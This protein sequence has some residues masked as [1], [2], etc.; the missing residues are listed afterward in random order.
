[1][2]V[3][4]DASR[5]LDPNVAGAPGALSVMIFVQRVEL[6]DAPVAYS[7]DPSA[8]RHSIYTPAEADLSEVRLFAGHLYRRSELVGDAAAVQRRVISI[9]QRGFLYTSELAAVAAQDAAS[10]L[11]VIG[12]SLWERCGEPVYW[13]VPATRA[14]VVVAFIHLFR[15]SG[16]TEK[17]DNHFAAD[18]FVEAQ[19]LVA[20]WTARGLRPHD[21]NERCFTEIRASGLHTP[22]TTWS[23]S[24]IAT[25][26]DPEVWTTPELRRQ[27]SLLYER[28]SL[29]HALASGATVDRYSADEL[30]SAQEDKVLSYLGT[31]IER[32]ID[33][34]T[35]TWPVVRHRKSWDR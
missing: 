32:G 30:T 15:I 16:A 2:P 8:S 1:M 13:I 25:A 6:T 14:G 29:D 11:V 7:W 17:N 34:S 31:A 35:V 19:S 24:S 20:E 5:L 4:V 10:T 27:L 26:L 22:G 28:L 21:Q 9:A 3:S 23:I 33:L 18:R 12:P